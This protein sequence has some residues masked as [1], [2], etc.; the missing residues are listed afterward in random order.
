VDF[1]KEFLVEGGIPA[2]ASNT[3]ELNLEPLKS[4]IQPFFINVDSVA[5]LEVELQRE[6]D[7]I[8]NQYDES[9]TTVEGIRAGRVTLDESRDVTDVIVDHLM[10]KA[11]HEVL[12]ISMA[13]VQHLRASVV[14]DT[15]AGP[16]I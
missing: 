14:P 4:W 13:L 10:L 15:R 7:S 1:V 6:L 11:K 5:D 8:T 12:E 9:K 3:N 2:V 16:S